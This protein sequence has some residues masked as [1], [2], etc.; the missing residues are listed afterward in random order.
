MKAFWYLVWTTSR[1]RMLSRARRVR[2][3]RY[4]AALVVGALYVWT[5]LLRPT[6]GTGALSFLLGQPTEMLVTVLMM[7]T[8]MGSWVFGSDTTALAFTQAELSILF[9][10]PLSRRALIGYKLFRSQIAVMINAL[11]WVFVLRRGS[12]ELASPLRAIALWVLFSTLSLH[13]LGAALVRSSWREHGAAGRHRHRWS[14]LVF[15][16]AVL[17]IAAAV[18]RGW[19]ILRFAAGPAAFFRTL[20]VVLA[21]PPA[22]W[23]LYPFL[24]VVQPTFA[25]TTAQWVSRMLPALAVLA[26]HA[27]W[28]LSSNAAFEDAAIEASAERARRLEAMR[29]R[30]T[31]TA[32]AAPR[33]ATGTLALASSGHP[34]LAIFWKNMLCLRRTAELRVFVGPVAIALA[35]GAAVSSGG[36]EPG[37]IFAACAVALAGMLLIFGGRL[38]RND[39]RHDMQHLSLLKVLPVKPADV[40]IAEVASA[41]LPMAAAQLVLLVAAYLATLGSS[42]VPIPLGVRHALVIAAPL[43]IVGVNAALLTV[44]N[45]TAVLFPAW[46]RLGPTVTTGVEALGQNVLATAANLLALGVAL[47]VPLLAV[48]GVVG[49]IV[50]ARPALIVAAVLVGTVVLAIEVYG[51]TRLIGRALARAEPLEAE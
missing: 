7:L 26:L 19:S 3:P 39:L 37:D 27:W 12:T 15:G 34:A 31:G 5:F 30:R 48:Y 42:I 49:P 41:A 20:G 35:L 40:V 16:A 32:R 43:A 33:K 9:P 25:H 13:R 47:I 1:N 4:A 21:R 36:A 46:V 10:A 8:L 38:I 44:Q 22:R 24:L 14:I 45:A 50:Q 29:S 2:S 11:I 17:A 51:A 18:V 6:R 28:V 23:G